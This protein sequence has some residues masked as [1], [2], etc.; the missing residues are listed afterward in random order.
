MTRQEEAMRRLPY[1]LLTVLVLASLALNL[2][3]IVQLERARQQALVLADQLTLSLMP[4]E[5]ERIQYTVRIRETVP[6]TAQIPFRENLNVPIRSTIPISLTVPIRQNVQ[7][8]VD[9]GLLKFNLDVP[10]DLEVP[11]NLDVPISLDVP[12]AISRTVSISTVV[13]IS[14]TI[15]V[16]IP[17]ADT[18]FGPALRQLREAVDRLR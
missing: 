14:L 12:V 9:T 7:V 10:I 11:L 6:V 17:L 13:P 3:I 16:D 1:L 18:P 8:P 2:F 15:P 4:L 5:N